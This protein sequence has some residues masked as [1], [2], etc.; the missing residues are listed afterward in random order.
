MRRFWFV[1]F[2]FAFALLPAQERS[3]TAIYISPAAGGTP[4]AHRFFDENI[5]MEVKNANY[6]LVYTPQDSDYI[7]TLA[8]AGEEDYDNPGETVNVFTIGVVRS[9]TGARVVE[10]SWEY[11]D[12]EEMYN[13]NLY[14]VYN[15]LANI[16]LSNQD[17]PVSDVPWWNNWLYLGFRA[18]PVITGYSFLTVADYESGY[19]A[20]IGFEA[21]AVADFRLFRFLSLQTE[22]LISFDRFDAVR[23]VSQG[24][25]QNRVT[26]EFTSLSLVIPLLFKV[27]LSFEKSILSFYAGAYFFESFPLTVKKESAGS[28]SIPVYKVLPPI[29]FTA[30]MDIGFR[31]GPGELFADLRYY[32]NFGT[33]VVHK[34]N[35]P[36]YIKDRISLSFGYKFPLFKRGPSPSPPEGPPV[37]DEVVEEEAAAEEL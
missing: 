20:G 22:V 17:S 18:A 13:W 29:G 1:P 11:R 25:I 31:I 28:E 15:A 26:D 3:D 24:N 8:I 6:R 10:Y 27:P 32:R 12:L 16:S 30:G 7:I 2:F 35:G 5:A 33:T 34:D 14:L 37:E 36:R 19:S 4:E 23:L 21:G 9:K